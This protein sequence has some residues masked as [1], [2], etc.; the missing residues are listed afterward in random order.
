MILVAGYAY[1]AINTDWSWVK[2]KAYYN[3]LGCY[4]RVVASHARL[5]IVFNPGLREEVVPA[6]VTGLLKN[7]QLSILGWEDVCN[8]G[9][10]RPGLTVAAI[11]PEARADNLTLAKGVLQHRVQVLVECSKMDKWHTTSEGWESLKQLRRTCLRVVVFDGGHHLSTIGTCPDIILVPVVNGYAAHS[12]MKDG[13]RVEK[14]KRLLVQTRAP[15]AIIAVPRWAVVKSPSCLGVLA[16]RAYLQL[17][18]EGK[19]CGVEFS[20]PVTSPGM[21]KLNGTV[22]CYVN[23]E[24]AQEFSGKLR[25]LGLRDVRRVYIALN[26]SRLDPTNALSYAERLQQHTGKPVMVVNEPVNVVDAVVDGFWQPG[27]RRFGEG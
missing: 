8:P 24:P 7:G 9:I 25:S 21:S 19:R 15:S 12:Y 10:P 26:Y 22:F 20:R 27:L 14:L 16:A 1:L 13:I 4:G 5:Q 2:N 23:G 18:R 17:V 11:T 6:Q 3:I